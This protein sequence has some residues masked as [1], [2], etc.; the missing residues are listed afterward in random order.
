MP[1]TAAARVSRKTNVTRHA[2]NFSV[3]ECPFD[4]TPN[5]AARAAIEEGIAALEGKIP[6][7]WV[8]MEEFFEDLHN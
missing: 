2:G 5:A 4:H 8:S 3:S 6:A 7:E 1:Q